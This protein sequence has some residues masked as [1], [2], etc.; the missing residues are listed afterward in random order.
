MPAELTKK[1]P[2]RYAATPL[3]QQYVNN[4]FTL[5]PIFEE[6][7]LYACVDAV[8][9]LEGVAKPF[10]IWVVRMV[11]A[12]ACLTQSEQ[13]GD[14]LYSD[15][16][17]HVNAALD[18]AEKVLHPGFISSIQALV[19][20]VIYATM[21]PHHFDSW[22]LIGA[23]SRA[24]VDLGIH[25]DPSKSSS[26]ARSKLEIRRRVYWCVY[27]LDRYV[28]VIVVVGVSH[29][30]V[31]DPSISGR[32]RWYRLAPS[33]S[34]TNRPTCTFHFTALLRHP[35]T[36]LHKVMFF[37]RLSTLHWTCSESVRYSLS[38]IWICSNLVVNRGGTR[39]RTFGRCTIV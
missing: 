10:D 31:A 38:G 24:M 21:D 28:D 39:T 13:R 8:Y 35:N 29:G 4:I 34:Q 20:L 33:L 5:L 30:M 18:Q 19:L 3:I 11:L 37:C 7:T 17:G 12:I 15:A 2:P 36:H 6:A 22:T 9:H 14:T 27:S 25:Q 1:L 32:H 26:V 16:V 23:A